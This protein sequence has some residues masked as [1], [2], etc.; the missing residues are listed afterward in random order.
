MHPNPVDD[1]VTL[2]RRSARAAGPAEHSQHQQLPA[3]G[4]AGAAGLR[5]P[6]PDV[7]LR[8]AAQPV[9]EHVA[10]V[11]PEAEAL[12]RHA[13]LEV[14]VRPDFVQMCRRD[15][16]GIQLIKSTASPLLAGISMTQWLTRVCV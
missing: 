6:R 8:A 14:R 16:A 4:D 3:V 2:R 12:H 1:L 5:R 10:A 9:L 15:R 7:R 13:L 11:A